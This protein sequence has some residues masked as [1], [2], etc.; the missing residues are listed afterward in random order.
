MATSII[1]AKKQVFSE[2]YKM[3]LTCVQNKSILSYLFNEHTF[4]LITI[5]I[6]I[7]EVELLKYKLV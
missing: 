6:A 7:T 4:G 1:I 3:V 2:F 5:S